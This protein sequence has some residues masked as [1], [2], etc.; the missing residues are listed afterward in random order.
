VTDGRQGSVRSFSFSI[1]INIWYNST[2]LADN[3]NP[4]WFPIAIPFCNLI[5][6]LHSFSGSSDLLVQL[7]KLKGLGARLYFSFS[8]LV[9]LRLSK[10]KLDSQLEAVP[11]NRILIESDV[12]CA[13][14]VDSAMLKVFQ[15]VCE[16]KQWSEE[17][18]IEQLRENTLEFYGLK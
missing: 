16:V 17:Q 1:P 12:H 5:S 15:V 2:M 18:G 3:S 8:S 4:F 11:C 14:Q 9:N 13:T 10:K 6:V 7:I